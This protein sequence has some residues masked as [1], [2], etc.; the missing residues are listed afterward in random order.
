[1]NRIHGR[2][3][4]P[5]LLAAWTMVAWAAC[6]FGGQLP[7]ATG[8]MEAEGGIKDNSFLIE[9]AYNQEPGVVQHIFN[10]VRG[11]DWT[12]GHSRTFDFTFTQEWPLG[13]ETHQFSYTVPSSSIFSHP[14]G[15]ISSE[16]SGFGDVLL[17]YRYQISQESECC[18]A[19]APRF[20]LI[21]PTGDESKGLGNGE[22]GY[23]FN[24]PISKEVGK[25]AYHFNAGLTVIPDVDAE[26]GPGLGRPRH[27][28]TGYNLGT[29]AIWLARN[30]L[31]FMLETVANW[32]EAFTDSGG[33][34]H[35]LAVLLSPG[36]RWAP[37]T[38]GDTQWVVGVGLPIGLTRDAPDIS[39]FFY[40][41]YEHRFKETPRNS[42]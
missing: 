21:L 16:E 39:L 6:A 31:N 33:I 37:Y 15:G 18:P 28:L 41:S 23:Q 8:N 38:K 42:E 36:V 14:A 30:D 26:L 9:E 1:M 5:A 7:T 3:L 32:D 4:S 19:I 24:L 13:S 35:T 12:N 29:S 20:S 40:L 27:T 10:F 25:W 34:D 11:W 22:V 2:L 17:N